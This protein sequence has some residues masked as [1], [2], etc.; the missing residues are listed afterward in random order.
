MRL[1]IVYWSWAIFIVFFM[2]SV[3]GT[4]KVRSHLNLNLG[5]VLNF[6]FGPP[7]DSASPVSL[8]N[9]GNATRHGSDLYEAG[10]NMIGRRNEPRL[11]EGQTEKKSIDRP[12]ARW[13]D[14]IKGVAGNWLV[15]G[16]YRE[17]WAETGEAFTQKGLH[18]D[19]F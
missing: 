5:H 16:I 12:Y 13:S 2:G 17:K 11:V 3:A 4:K 15:E 6:G 1:R 14:D 10:A 9:F 19:S 18:S 8:F 7:I